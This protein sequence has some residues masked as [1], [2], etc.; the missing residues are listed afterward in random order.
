VQT[1]TTKVDKAFAATLHPDVADLRPSFS[2]QPG[3]QIGPDNV[4]GDA[5]IQSEHPREFLQYL[6][7]HPETLAQLR[8][9]MPAQLFRAIG[10]IEALAVGSGTSP[11]PAAKTVTDAPAPPVTLGGRSTDVV[12]PEAAAIRAGDYRA[13]RALRMQKAR[14]TLG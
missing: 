4:I 13:L 3:E 6:S 5:I 1:F 12:D 7:D 11:A 14:A 10:R 9:L 8:R 2:L